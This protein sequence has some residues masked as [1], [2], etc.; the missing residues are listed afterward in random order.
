MECLSGYKQCLAIP[1]RVCVC[2]RVL[3]GLEYMFVFVIFNEPI[4]LFVILS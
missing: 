2:V 4:K 3:P 1:V